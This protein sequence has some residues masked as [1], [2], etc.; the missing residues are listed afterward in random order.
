M[1]ISIFTKAGVKRRD[2]YILKRIDVEYLVAIDNV[3]GHVIRS[4]RKRHQYNRYHDFVVCPDSTVPGTQDH[5]LT[6]WVAQK[7]LVA[8][9]IGQ[10]Q[11]VEVL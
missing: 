4:Q 11:A 7:L 1:K 8:G 5:F 2:L 6:S 10:L 3:L 9:L